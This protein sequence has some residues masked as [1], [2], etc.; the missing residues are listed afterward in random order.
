M[1]F[2]LLRAFVVVCLIFLCSV[3]IT[4]CLDRTP[5]PLVVECNFALLKTPQPPLYS[6]HSYTCIWVY[7][8]RY[9]YRCSL[10]PQGSL[11][12]LMQFILKLHLCCYV[13]YVIQYCNYKYFRRGRIC[14][15][16]F[17]KRRFPPRIQGRFDKKKLQHARRLEREYEEAEAGSFM[18]FFKYRERTMW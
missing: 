1:C 5:L 9:V 7:C 10:G 18:Y 17:C 6:Y 2:M 13:K 16:G 15:Q 14:N 12:Y 3:V 8:Y 11:L 4:N